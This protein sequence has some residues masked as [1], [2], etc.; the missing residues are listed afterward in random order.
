MAF[1]YILKTRPNIA[2]HPFSEI[3]LEEGVCHDVW[4]WSRCVCVCGGRKSSVKMNYRFP[5]YASPS[6][7]RAVHPIVAVEDRRPTSDIEIR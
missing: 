1:F 6:L 7:L 4:E 5:G 2:L 3:Y